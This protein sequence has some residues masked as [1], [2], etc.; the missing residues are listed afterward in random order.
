MSVKNANVSRTS[1]LFNS[2]KFKV[3]FYF[4]FVILLISSILTYLSVSNTNKIA[5]QIL[6]EQGKYTTDHIAASING[7]KF[8]KLA[9]SLDQSSPDY[10]EI[11]LKM[12]SSKETINCTFLYTMSKISGTEYNYIVDAS[13]DPSDTENFSPIGTVE[14]ISEFDPAITVAMD[15]GKTAYSN[16]EYT[17]E[18]GWNI[19][20]YSP[21]KNSSGKVVGIVGCDFFAGGIYNQIQS[22]TSYYIF[23]SI[24]LSILSVMFL[25]IFSSRIFKVVNKL[26]NETNKI[27]KGNLDVQ[28]PS[29]KGYELQ[30]LSNSFGSMAQALGDIIRS[31]KNISVNITSVSSE[32]DKCNEISLAHSQ[33][34]SATISELYESSNKQALIASSGE[35]KIKG[36][37]SDLNAVVQK[38][39]LTTE[40]SNNTLSI[41]DDGMTKVRNQRE[42]I[43]QSV[44]AISKTSASMNQL[45]EKTSQIGEVINLI[46]NIASQTNMLALNASIEA[47][48]AGEQGRGFAVVASEI[49]NLAETSTNSV[50]TVDSLI[51]DVLT[52][53]ANSLSEIENTIV[54]INQQK[55]A[56]DDSYQAFEQISE[57]FVNINTHITSVNN[58]INEFANSNNDLS[59][60][61]NNLADISNVN[62]KCTE[63]TKEAIHNQV[64]QIEALAY[65]SK[66]LKAAV[67]ILNN[68][69]SKF[70]I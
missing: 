58:Y 50:K 57:A 44:V 19:S 66:D 7:D 45:A 5:S 27:S 22:S 14:N 46:K 68:T 65:L 38:I 25:I 67:D 51:K 15:T 64:E 61:I 28:L 32:V 16:I 69:V 56:M 3:I 55:S 63:E 8:E 31:I 59:V 54:I 53:V 42:N 29:S 70:T 20:S 26:I 41:L 1:K 49:R 17:D 52:Y 21:I 18:Y 60:Q 35:D 23:I 48:R 39:D 9:S 47:A 4:L 43:S 24:I 6:G 33:E 13:A 62:S 34:I 30:Q 2:I 36:M 11:R 10:E 37:L 12:L 40:T